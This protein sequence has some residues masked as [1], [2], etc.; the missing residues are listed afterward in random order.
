MS[1][2]LVVCDLQFECARVPGV[3]K[4]NVIGMNECEFLV[5]SLRCENVLLKIRHGKET[6]QISIDRDL[7][8]VKHS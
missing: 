3:V 6:M 7:L 1:E 4:I 8:Q 2:Q 5:G